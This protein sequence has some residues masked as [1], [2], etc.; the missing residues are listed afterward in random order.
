MAE[1]DERH[2]LE[3]RRALHAS[4][5]RNAEDMARSRIVRIASSWVW[6]PSNSTRL[7]S[8]ASRSKAAMRPAWWR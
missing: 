7:P 2:T 4:S 3:V 6:N 5:R 8:S 1:K